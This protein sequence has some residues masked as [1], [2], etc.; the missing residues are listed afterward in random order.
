M[1]G[2]YVLRIPLELLRRAF[3][4]DG[5]DLFAGRL[6]LEPRFNIAPT[7][8]VPIVRGAGGRTVEIL[9][10][11][12]GGRE[13]VMARW[14][15]VPAWAKEA[16]IGSRMI[17][18]RAEG[19]ADKPAFRAAFRSRRCVVPASGFYEWQRR[20]SGRKQPYLIRR[21]DGA[22]IG[23][24]GL[25]EAW[26]DP[27]TG[28]QLTTCAIVTCPPNEVMAELHDRMPVILDPADYAA[29]LE[30]PAPAAADLLRPCPAEWLEAVPVST[31]VN[32]PANDDAGL[33][34]P[35]DDAAPSQG[36]LL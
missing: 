16:S 24:A 13:L 17:N 3:G 20:E 36:A 22:P 10:A 28:E 25:W 11:G 34:E 23:F 2:R 31:R 29:W 35:V 30:A 14:G 27:A 32:S 6:D 15:L 8:S 19:I 21:A 4:V 9:R 26:R 33:I 5:S 1:C 12:E 18:A 7:Q